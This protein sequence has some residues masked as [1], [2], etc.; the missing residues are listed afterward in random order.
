ML[1][2][3]RPEGGKATANILRGTHGRIAMPVL[4][5]QGPAA[6]RTEALVD[7][8]H[9]AA[10]G[11]AAD[12]PAGRLQDPVHAGIAVS[13]SEAVAAAVLIIALQQVAFGAES[14]QAGTDHDRTDQ[15]VAAQVDPF[16]HTARRER[17]SR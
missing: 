8:H 9:H 6:G 11:F 7:Q 12:H 2:C 13:K 16:G 3:V 14:G 10:V 5:Q 15:P 17:R 1:F 4:R